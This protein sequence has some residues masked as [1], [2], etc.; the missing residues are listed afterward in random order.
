MDAVQADV[1]TKRRVG[2]EQVRYAEAGLRK[3]VHR[4]ETEV[5][6]AVLGSLRL[7]VRV[8]LRHSCVDRVHV[9]GRQN[10]VG[11]PWHVGTGRRRWSLGQEREHVSRNEEVIRAEI[12]V[13]THADAEAEQRRPFVEQFPSAANTWKVGGVARQADEDA[14]GSSTMNGGKHLVVVALPVRVRRHRRDATGTRWK[15]VVGRKLDG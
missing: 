8:H 3:A 5:C 7:H 6:V 14:A 10:V 9:A 12:T 11:G 1:R 4:V 15:Y 2:E 13:K